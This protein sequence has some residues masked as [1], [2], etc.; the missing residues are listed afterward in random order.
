M[1][2]AESDWRLHG[3]EDYLSR[4]TLK[5]SRYRSR[6]KASDH[7]HCEFCWAKFCESQAADCLRAGYATEDE[8]RWICRECFADFS[9]RFAWK[10]VGADPPLE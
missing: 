10:V 5:W 8:H 3:Q 6:S 7:D 9:E 2:Q 1:D 4:V